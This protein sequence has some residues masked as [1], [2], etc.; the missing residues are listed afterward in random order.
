MSAHEDDPVASKTE[1]AEGGKSPEPD[2]KS[3][4][5]DAEYEGAGI[6]APSFPLHCSVAR[7]LDYVLLCLVPAM[8]VLK[9]RD[10]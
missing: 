3:S 1:P 4:I 2:Q 5:R 7:A 9:K 10:G 8:L 6:P